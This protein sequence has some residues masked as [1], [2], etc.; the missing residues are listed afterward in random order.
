MNF[1]FYGIEVLPALRTRPFWGS[2][3]RKQKN[4]GNDYRANGFC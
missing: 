3:R 4:S 2:H 1:D